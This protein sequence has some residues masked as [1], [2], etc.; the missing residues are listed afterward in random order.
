MLLQVFCISCNVV[1][2]LVFG[3]FALLFIISVLYVCFVK[4]FLLLVIYCSFGF[5]IMSFY[6]FREVLRRI[7]V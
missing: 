4:L 6:S 1:F 5:C 3:G 7:F 2:R